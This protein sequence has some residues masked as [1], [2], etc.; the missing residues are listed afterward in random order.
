MVKYP[1]LSLGSCIFQKMCTALLDMSRDTTPE[2]PPD[3]PTSHTEGVFLKGP[4]LCRRTNW[5]KF[6]Q[7]FGGSQN[8][9][10]VSLGLMNF[11]WGNSFDTIDI[12]ADVHL[13]TFIH[14][15]E[16]PRCGSWRRC[17][18]IKRL[19]GGMLLSSRTGSA[20]SGRGTLWKLYF[21]GLRVLD[22]LYGTS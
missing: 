9:C 12:P 1:I 18:V 16:Y 5:K 13:W 20:L 22:D 14:L 11:F 3:T 10:W 17:R 4:R 15:H 19:K 7:C 6:P 2:L 8:E 21:L